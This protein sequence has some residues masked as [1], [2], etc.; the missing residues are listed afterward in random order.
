LREALAGMDHDFIVREERPASKA[1][2]KEKK[3][4]VRSRL[5]VP[6]LPVDRA[7]LVAIAAIAII[8]VPLNALFLQDGRHPAPLFQAPAPLA[9]RADR[10]PLP[11]PRPVSA[12]ASAR[13]ASAKPEAAHAEATPP[14]GAQA[15]DKTRDAI[16]LLLVGSAPEDVDRKVLF[17][18]RA[19]VKLGYNVHVD[20][21]FG[22]STRQALE[23]FERDCGLPVKGELTQKIMRQLSSRSGF[24]SE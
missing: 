10:A 20:G 13:P 8:G 19:L 24:A 16:G 23:K 15:H 4:S 21:R 1:Q 22:G 3:A 12:N 6:K 14:S 2:R 9:A 18:Q 5:R 7:V 11:P 17:A